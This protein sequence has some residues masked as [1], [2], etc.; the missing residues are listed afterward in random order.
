MMVECL[1]GSLSGVRPPTADLPE[2]V[3]A[4]ARMGAF[5]ITI[6]PRLAAIGDG[7]AAHVAEWVELYKTAT[8]QGARYPAERAAR[9]EAECRERGIPLAAARRSDLAKVGKEIG[10][11]FD[12]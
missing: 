11:P 6:D 2:G 3:G 5:V 12:L 10:L 4:P 9:M 8:G 1:A 7:Y